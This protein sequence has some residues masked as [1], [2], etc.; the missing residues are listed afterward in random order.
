M[1]S[2]HEYFCGKVSYQNLRVDNPFEPQN[3]KKIKRIALRKDDSYSHEKEIRFVIKT[4][5][6]DVHEILS[7]LLDLSKLD[8]NIITHPKMPEWKINNIAE[9]M[10]SKEL[11]NKFKK[12]SIRLRY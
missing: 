9:L 1:A 2:I 10:K 12:L 11:G 4:K 3:L 5:K 7:E 8:F 6:A